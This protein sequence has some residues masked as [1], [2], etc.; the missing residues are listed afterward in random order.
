M[1]ETIFLKLGGSLITDK[2]KEQ[3]ALL[4]TIDHIAIQIKEY[5]EMYPEV[6]LLIGHGSGSFGHFAAQRF[7]TRDG[8]RTPE[9]WSGFSSVWQAAHLLNQIVVDRF[10]LSGIPVISLPLSAAAVTSNRKI[11]TW[12]TLPIQSALE[13][14]LLPIIFGDV[15]LDDQMGG[16]IL[17]TE[18][19]FAELVP[20]LHPDRILLAGL[21][22]GVWEDFPKCT[23][24][25]SVIT[26]QTYPEIASHILGSA[27]VD[28]TGGMTAKVQD[29]LSL[30][31]KDHHLRVQIFSGLAAD[32]IKAALSDITVG[33]VIKA[34]Q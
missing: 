34:D 3:T 20:L 29:M 21:E 18:E 26:P 5:R 16:T 7:H 24:L 15:V 31:K 8:V 30:I 28:V 22:P 23:R 12:N 13:N 1:S 11:R 33:T 27:S 4:S 10:S 14:H 17:S 9:Q 25:V 19:Q 6:Q 32:K 2:D